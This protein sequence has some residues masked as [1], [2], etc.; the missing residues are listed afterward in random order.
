[1]RFAPSTRKLSDS[2][3]VIHRLYGITS[4]YDA[5]FEQQVEDLLRLGLDR[6]DMD[7]GIVSRITGDTYEVVATVVPEGVAMAPGDQF[8][9]AETYCSITVEADGPVGFENAGESRYARHPAYGAFRLEAYIGVP[10]YRGA[11]F[12]GTLNFSSP[13]ARERQFEEVDLDSLKLMGGWLSTELKRRQTEEE[14]HAVRQELEGLV[15]TDPLTELLNRRGVRETFERHAERS[16]FDGSPLS[17]VLVD[18]DDFKTIN[19]RWGHSTGDRVI[20]A[21]AQRVRESLRP[22]DVAGRIG[23]DEFLAVLPSASI[24]DAR[25]VAERIAANVR[26]MDVSADGQ[27]VPLTVSIGVARLPIGVATVTD[28]LAHIEDLLAESKRAGKNTVTVSSTLG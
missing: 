16:G 15:R 21:V 10:I 13:K 12:F 22:T 28:V 2:E 4:R 9:L 26:A 27:P 14:L 11:E 19:D 1:M 6:F 20:R 5:G 17:C 3:M 25:V 23:G 7:I 8:Q 24:H 18:I